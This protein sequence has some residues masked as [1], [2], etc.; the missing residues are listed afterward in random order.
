MTDAT[1]AEVD[2]EHCF[3]TKS[4]SDGTATFNTTIQIDPYHD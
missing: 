3:Y 4:M 1:C 2:V